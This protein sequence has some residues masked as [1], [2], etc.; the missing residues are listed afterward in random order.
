MILAGCQK[1]TL[2]DFPEKVACIVFTQGCN[3]RCPFCHNSELW[4]YRENGPITEEE[5]FSFL[6]GRREKLDGVVVSGGEPTL[7]PDLE[8]FLCRIRD[9]GFATKLDT[10]GLQPAV[11]AKLL[12][13]KLLDF[14][15]M[16]LKHTPKNYAVA[17]GV[18]VPEEL[19]RQSL[20]ILRQSAIDYE[21]RTTAVPGIHNL[22]DL[23]ALGDLVNGAPRFTLQNFSPKSAANPY[24]RKTTPFPPEA[25][26]S[27]RPIF[28]SA[29]K[30]FTIR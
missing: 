12:D 15:A 7:Q 8:N 17:C 30:K 11:L 25:L 21:L 28:E 27:L 19:I 2:I 4:A 13:E 9:Q 16:D 23:A 6:A 22:E 10:N 20:G 29:V 24:L 5:F 26:E 1:C 14:V 18:P 3:L